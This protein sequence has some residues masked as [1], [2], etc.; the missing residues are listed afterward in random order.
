[1]Y[2]SGHIVGAA[3]I[4]VG[5]IVLMWIIPAIYVNRMVNQCRRLIERYEAAHKRAE[6][7]SE[8]EFNKIW[9][10]PYQDT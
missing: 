10:T 2:T 7:M 8:E 4:C 5:L 9:E 1:M 6:A 3:L